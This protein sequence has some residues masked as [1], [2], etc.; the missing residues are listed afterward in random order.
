MPTEIIKEDYFEF[1]DNLAK[2]KTDQVFYNSGPSHAA[3]V[4]SRIFEYS[5][6]EVKMFCGGFSGQVSNEPIYLNALEKFLSRDKIKLQVV[7]EDY[8]NNKNGKIYNYLKK[9]KDKVEFFRTTGKVNMKTKNE[10]GV[11]ENT[12]IHFAIGDNS[13]LRVET[14]TTSFE[15]EVNFAANN[16][17]VFNDL[18][19]VII[20]SKE[21]T[22]KIDLV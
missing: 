20:N 16:V 13:M 18:F 4:M 19:E 10:A 11:D 7:V 9:Y 1:V 5:T 12:F 15:A 2:N 8:E 21:R 22:S 14:N 17:S 6:K 3:I